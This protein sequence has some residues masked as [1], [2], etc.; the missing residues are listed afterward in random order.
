L[1]RAGV[2]SEV[3]EQ[4]GAFKEIG[5]GIQLGPNV[6]KMLERLPCAKRSTATR[7]FPM[8]W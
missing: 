5:A 2:R 3:L 1:A 7:Y 6:F 4:A 8:P